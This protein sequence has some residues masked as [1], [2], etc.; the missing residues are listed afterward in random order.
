MKPAEPKES[1][2]P[3]RVLVVL[4]ADPDRRRL[5]R[6]LGQPGLG[7]TPSAAASLEEALPL[8]ELRRVDALVGDLEALAAL[9]QGRGPTYEEAR[10]LPFCLLV[11]AGEEERAAPYLERGSAELILQTTGDYQRLIPPLLRRAH[12]RRETSWEE[13]ARVIRHEMNNPLTGILGNAELV[14]AEP[15]R[16]TAKTRERLNTIIELAVRLRD[17]VG[18]LE[19]HLHANGNLS[20]NSE[21]PGETPP[22]ELRGEVLQ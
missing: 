1:A 3:L 21:G 11:P 16:L 18:H 17:V 2:R 12:R 5:L 4:R 22:R 10:W 14:L 15:T 19:K 13:V 7:L 20:N 6:H 9:R 8:L